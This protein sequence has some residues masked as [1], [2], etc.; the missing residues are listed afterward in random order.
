MTLIN[1]EA[2]SI[3][4]KACVK[5]GMLVNDQPQDSDSMVDLF[6]TQVE[7]RYIVMFS[8]SIQKIGVLHSTG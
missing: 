1:L 4:S 3:L 2:I 5:H 7:N 6:H 8:E